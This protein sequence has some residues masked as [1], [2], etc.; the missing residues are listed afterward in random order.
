MTAPTPEQTTVAA[1]RWRQALPLIEERARRAQSLANLQQQLQQAEEQRRRG[2]YPGELVGALRQQITA[3]EVLLAD[4]R[5]QVDQILTP[6]E[7]S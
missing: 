2:A 7:E 1:A 3:N 6:E 4:L 5:Q